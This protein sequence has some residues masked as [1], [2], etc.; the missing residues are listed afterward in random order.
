MDKVNLGRS[1]LKVTPL[2]LGTWQAP[3]GMPG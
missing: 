2:A 3:E 1:G